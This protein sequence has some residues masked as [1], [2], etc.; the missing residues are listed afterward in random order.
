MNPPEDRSK[1][2]LQQIHDQALAEYLTL[3]REN[4]ANEAANL[5]AQLKYQEAKQKEELRFKDLQIEALNEQLK[6]NQES[7]EK[8][9]DSDGSEI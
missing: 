8:E 9:D 7:L 3:Q 2:K 5:F 1:E 4:H 6:E